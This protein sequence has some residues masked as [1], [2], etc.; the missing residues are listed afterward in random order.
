MKK[1]FLRIFCFVLSFIMMTSI[2]PSA[3]ATAGVETDKSSFETQ[4]IRFIQDVFPVLYG[5]EGTDCQVS[6]GNRLNTYVIDQNGYLQATD[7]HVYPLFCDEHMVGV[8]NVSLEGND[9]VGI[10]MGEEYAV[11]LDNALSTYEEQFVVIYEDNGVYVKKETTLPICIAQYSHE[12][13]QLEYT[14]SGISYGSIDEYVNVPLL[15]RRTASRSG[16]Q[17]IG[18]TRVANATPSC[19]PEGICWAACMAMMSNHYRST[20]YEAIDIHD[21]FFCLTSGYHSEEKSMLQQLNM[22]VGGP[23]YSFSSSDVVSCINN[24]RVML[25]DLQRTGGAHNV[26]AN[27]YTY[28]TSGTTYVLFIDPNSSGQKSALFPSTGN[29]TISAGG[30]NYSVH[31]YMS[32]YG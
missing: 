10:N 5:Q 14:A 30:W 1:Q 2:S 15:A 11:E 32:V 26:V 3:L 7:Y 13:V 9:I 20:D 22:I 27:G 4:M 17:T 29:I 18:I 28:G 19:C 16:T 8:I 12:A 24:G 21:M 31:C 25:L 23:Y 6:Y